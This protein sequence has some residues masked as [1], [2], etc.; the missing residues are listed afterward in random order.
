MKWDGS[1]WWTGCNIVMVVMVTLHQPAGRHH[2]GYR[3]TNGKHLQLAP[4]LAHT[5]DMLRHL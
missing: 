1:H 2:K 3:H 5:A 4:G